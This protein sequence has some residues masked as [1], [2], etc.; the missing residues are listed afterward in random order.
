VL[1]FVHLVLRQYQVGLVRLV[2]GGLPEQLVLSRGDH[3]K[4]KI[5]HYYLGEKIIDNLT[6]IILKIFLKKIHILILNPKMHFN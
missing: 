1:V 4:A 3:C 5:N 6:G 2:C